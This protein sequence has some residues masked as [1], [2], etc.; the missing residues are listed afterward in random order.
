M[1]NMALFLQY[2]KKSIWEGEILIQIRWLN[3]KKYTLPQT[4]RKF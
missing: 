4:L 1:F 2:A 3:I